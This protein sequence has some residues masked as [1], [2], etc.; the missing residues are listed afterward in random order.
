MS[1]FG[2]SLLRPRLRQLFIDY[3]RK[4]SP[5]GPLYNNGSI[6][7]QRNA[8]VEEVE[9]QRP[10]ETYDDGGPTIKEIGSENITCAVTAV[11]ASGTKQPRIDRSACNERQGS[12]Y[13]E[14]SSTQSSP[15]DDLPN[16]NLLVLDATEQDEALLKTEEKQMGLL[17]QSLYAYVADSLA[18]FVCSLPETHFNR[19]AVSDLVELEAETAPLWFRR[20]IEKAQMREKERYN[21]PLPNIQPNPSSSTPDDSSSNHPP[22]PN[23]KSHKG[24]QLQT[25]NARMRLLRHPVQH[26]QMHP[27]ESDRVARI[28]SSTTAC[29]RKMQKMWI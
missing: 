21:T 17:G 2:S 12:G 3:H 4:S 28:P 23:K 29:S 22:L 1:Q 7:V 24:V 27:R 19:K 14:A 25:G 10:E 11:D 15:T 13:T 16:S 6:F 20:G 9:E 8:E 26:H 18:E 5:G